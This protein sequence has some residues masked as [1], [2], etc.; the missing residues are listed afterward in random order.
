MAYVDFEEDESASENGGPLVPGGAPAQSAPTAAPTGQAAKPKTSGRFAD[1]GE[2]LRVNSPQQFGGQVAGRIGSDIQGAQNTLSDTANQFKSRADQSVVRDDQN[3]IGQLDTAPQGIDEKAFS[4]LRDAEYKGPVTF[5]N[6]PDLYKQ[7]TGNVNSAAGKAQAS[8]TEGGRFAL[9]D[10]Y[11]G[12]PQ[13]SQGQKTLDNL[14]VQ[15]DPGS[16]QAFSQMQDNA[17]N[18]QEN[19]ATTGKDLTAYGANA[20]ATTDST[21]KAAR[22]GLG[23]DNV[24]NLTGSGA[25]GSLQGQIGERATQTRAETDRIN[26]AIEAGNFGDISPQMKE[27]L[28]RMAGRTYGVKPLS[29]LDAIQSSQV[30][31]PSVSTADETARLRALSNLAQMDDPYA[32]AEDIGF[33]NDKPLYNFN[34][35]GYENQVGVQKKKFENEIIAP[36]QKLTEAQG[37]I[38][39][40]YAQGG[41]PSASDL[42]RVRDAERELQTVYSKYEIPWVDTSVSGGGT[43]GGLLR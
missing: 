35:E 32:R 1:L 41:T 8:K 24:G 15:N 38:A 23:I 3:L 10:N 29:Y 21:R 28:T 17:K 22:S 37:I 2:Y 6:A 25:I 7:A 4:G 9:L 18:L 26:A 31:N 43:A 5:G 33:L 19:L 12:R 27:I 16:Q 20:K 34:G 13:Y 11:F 30:T 36:K 40:I 14:L 42:G 39:A